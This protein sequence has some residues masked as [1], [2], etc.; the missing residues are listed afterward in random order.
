M[1]ALN[2]V[3]KEPKGIKNGHDGLLEKKSCSSIPFFAT[4]SKFYISRVPT[5]VDTVH[6]LQHTKHN[7]HSEIFSTMQSTTAFIL[8]ALSMSS[9]ALGQDN[10]V[11]YE[12]YSG[13][14]PPSSPGDACTGQRLGQTAASSDSGELVVH[15]SKQ[16]MESTNNPYN[17]F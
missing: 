10:S 7:T 12:A 16:A 17:L 3:S 6:T 2:T 11:I 5:V 13:Q 15:P 8:F 14:V 1:R 9:T 4:Y